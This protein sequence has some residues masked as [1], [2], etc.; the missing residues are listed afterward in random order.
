MPDQLIQLKLN[1]P[2]KLMMLMTLVVALF[3]SWYVV[4]WYLGNTIAEYVDPSDQRLDH[5][6]MAVSLAPNDPLPHWR[7]GKLMETLLPPDQI[8]LV[9]A[10]YEKAVSLS[11]RDYRFWTALGQALEQAGDYPRAE[12]SMREAVKLAPAYAHP[13]WHLGNLLLRTDRYDE[14]FAELQRASEADPT[15]QSQLFALAWQVN[16]DDFESLTAAVG[17]APATRAEFSRYLLRRGRIDEG[18]R[19]WGTLTNDQKKANRP[20]ADAIVETLIAAKRFHLAVGVWNDV[21]PGSTHRAEF[22]KILDGGFENNLAHGLK[23][24][25]GWRVP[26][27]TQ[28]QIGITP[29]LGHTGNRSLRLFFQAR[30]QLEAINVTHLIAIMPNTQYEFECFLR[31]E[32]LISAIT[33][34]VGISDASDSISLASSTAAPDGDNDWQRIS[35]SFKTR[36]KS[37][38][39]ILSISRAPCGGDNPVCPIFGTVWYDDFDLKPGK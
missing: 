28:V 19:L 8:P 9:V 29:N 18:L 20:V 16:K 3:A 10:E 2:T 15:L 38:A 21:A 39:V 26:S 11:P 4:R 33:P 17:P 5:A 25:F 24:P 31:T 14:A 12:K 37:E 35:L 7:L 32:N 34:S 1:T 6:H 23:S 30:S 13:R 27:S 22:G 36:A